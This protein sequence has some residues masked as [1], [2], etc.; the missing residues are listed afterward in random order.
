MV[1]PEDLEAELNFALEEARAAANRI[2]ADPKRFLDDD[3]SGF[4]RANQLIAEAGLDV[5]AEE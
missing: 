4:E 1:P 5:C 2:K 3:N